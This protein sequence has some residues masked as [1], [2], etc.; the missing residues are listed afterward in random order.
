MA[1]LLFVLVALSLLIR[2]P[3]SA[4]ARAHEAIGGAARIAAVRSLSMAGVTLTGMSEPEGPARDA[5]VP[6]ELKIAFPD[7]YVRA[8]SGMRL[9]FDGVTPIHVVPPPPPGVRVLRTPVN[10][11]AI[12]TVP[13]VRWLIG[14]FADARGMMDL[15]IAAAP[16]DPHLLLV[17]GPR[18]GLNTGPKNFAARIDLDSATGMPLRVRYLDHL[19]YGGNR[20]ARDV[21]VMI[22]FEDRRLVDGLMLPHRIVR[23]VEGVR[24]EDVRFREVKVN[25][26]LTDADFR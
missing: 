4:L 25:P 20:R 21:E 6:T 22:A 2:Q 17:T 1:R 13:L 3:E 10:W 9:G 5:P 23:T 26:I 16:G 8:R 11:V 24:W 15:K 7:R 18:M 12:Q 19:A 14:I